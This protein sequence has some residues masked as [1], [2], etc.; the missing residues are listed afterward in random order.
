MIRQVRLLGICVTLALGWATQFPAG[1]ALADGA[2]AEVGIGQA[3]GNN[4]PRPVVGAAAAAGPLL[5][6]YV[7][8]DFRCPAGMARQQLFVSIADT[9]QVVE[10]PPG[11]P[12]P[13]TL[14]LDVPLDQLPWFDPPAAACAAA[15]E[16][17]PPDETD[18]QGIGYFRLHPGATGFVTLTCRAE[19]GRE[20][21]ANSTTSLDVWLS[22]PAPAERSALR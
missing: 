19:D 13:V 18:D 16:H 14:R 12:P 17:R 6:F 4:L 2:V 10:I 21:A 3:I 7:A 5:P 15:R 22:C 9:A 11:Q 1:A 20:A 8:L